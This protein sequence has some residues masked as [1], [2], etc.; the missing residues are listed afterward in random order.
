MGCVP[1]LV[2]HNLPNFF[3]WTFREVVVIMTLLLLLLLLFI[4]VYLVFLFR[5]VFFSF[6]CFFRCIECVCRA[7]RIQYDDDMTMRNVYAY[8]WQRCSYH[9]A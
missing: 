3:C 7:C 6:L 8:T 2:Y 1:T 9:V 4:V 5:F